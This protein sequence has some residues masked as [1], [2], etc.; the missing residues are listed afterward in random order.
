MT[1]H[2]SVHKLRNEQPGI[3]ISGYLKKIGPLFLGLYYLLLVLFAFPLSFAVH[4]PIPPGQAAFGGVILSSIV[5]GINFWLGLQA[6][7]KDRY[8]FA[9]YI[10]QNAFLR[11]IYY[12]Y[13]F[14]SSDFKLSEFKFPK[15]IDLWSTRILTP[16]FLAFAT[17]LWVLSIKALFFANPPQHKST[18]SAIAALRVLIFE[19]LFSQLLHL[20]SDTGRCPSHG[21]EEKIKVHLGDRITRFHTWLCMN[22]ALQMMQK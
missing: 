1:N 16:L 19:I 15:E 2:R 6:W 8:Q 5:W 22:H 9:E 13:V 4:T 12:R 11:F 10:R 20:E 21:L 7:S 14:L 18:D 17:A 3:R